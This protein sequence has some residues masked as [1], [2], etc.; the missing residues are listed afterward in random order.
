MLNNKKLIDQ[1]KRWFKEWLQYSVFKN[2]TES[3]H[4][5]WKNTHPGLG[6]A[7]STQ[8]IWHMGLVADVLA[9]KGDHELYEISTTKGLKP[10]VEPG[11]P[12]NLKGAAFLNMR[13]VNYK[14]LRYGTD[15]PANVGK[16]K[17]RIGTIDKFGKEPRITDTRLAFMNLYW[18]DNEF[19]S[20]YARKAAGAPDYPANPA[21]SGGNEWMKPFPGALLMFGQMEG[22]IW[23]YGN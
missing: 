3:D 10:I 7:Y 17:Y 23:P 4:H 6:W 1:G 15:K 8:F 2:N 16:N 22:K 19:T 9:R 20:L 14:V 12:K 11:G 21:G 13:M 18:K 5:R